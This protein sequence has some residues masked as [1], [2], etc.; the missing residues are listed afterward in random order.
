MSNARTRVI[1]I[2]AASVLSLSGW[3][4]VAQE[5]DLAEEF[6]EANHILERLSFYNDQLRDQISMQETLLTEINE[7]VDYARM[8]SDEDESPLL[9]LMDEMTSS[10]EQFIEADLPFHMDTRREQVQQARDLVDHPEA[11]IRQKFQRLLNVYQAETNYGN[12]IESYEDVI[13]L[14]GMEH[15]VDVVR[16]GR[17][18]L[19]FQSKDRLHTGV[20]DKNARQWVEL[21][22]GSYRTAVERALRV[23]RGELAAEMLQVPIHAPEIVQ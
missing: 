7:D 16:V 12:S 4:A 21:D 14:D 9:A 22:P 23:G 15:E 13:Q 10:L 6:R 19:A 3:S 17:I 18:S 11:G 1:T 5:P 8:I 2:I 20:W